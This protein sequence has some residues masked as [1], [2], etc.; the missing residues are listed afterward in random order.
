MS[1]KPPCLDQGA[2]SSL[3]DS[4][5]DVDVCCQETIIIKLSILSKFFFYRYCPF[6]STWKYFSA[7]NFRNFEKSDVSKSLFVECSN[8]KKEKK[9]FLL[10][11]F[12]N[13]FHSFRNLISEVSKAANVL[14]KY[15]TLVT[16]DDKCDDGEVL[17]AMQCDDQTRFVSHTKNNILK[18]KNNIFK[19][20]LPLYI[21]YISW[22]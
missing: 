3:S 15:T 2:C 4:M 13:S 12:S 5:V 18:N 14:S 11:W 7:T 21:K 9:T 1:F 17:S 22:W 6:Y 19:V 16:I 10:N 8:F 20:I